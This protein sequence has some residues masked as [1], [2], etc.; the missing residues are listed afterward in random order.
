[1]RPLKSRTTIESLA[2]E[3]RENHGIGLSDQL[4]PLWLAK[5]ERIE[6]LFPEGHG[7]DFHGRIEYISGETPIPEEHFFMYLPEGVPRTRL[8]F[9]CAHELG[10]YFLPHHQAE[11]RKGGSHFSEPSFLSDKEME[12]EADFFA[13]ALLIPED[14][15]K[16]RQ[17]E[18][19]YLE[20]NQV[21]KMAEDLNV[22]PEC[23]VVRYI[24]CTWDKCMLIVSEN[25]KVCYYR[26][27]EEAEEGG[28]GGL[29]RKEIPLKAKARNLESSRQLVQG[30]ASSVD[31]FSERNKTADLYE[32]SYRIGYRSRT[33][34]LLS[35]R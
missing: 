34:T 15:I 3:V 4:D 21:M 12:R 23:A 13:G 10:H 2:K 33:I 11:L 24:Q 8:N 35:F 29:G 17:T 30:S 22:S 18:D 25:G 16:R 31:W 9:S 20:L 27:S 19:D 5:E 6:V 32:E 26:A 14:T 1:L 28:F 7:N